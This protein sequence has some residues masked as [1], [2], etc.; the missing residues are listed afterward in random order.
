MAGFKTKLNKNN[1][2]KQDL[3][4]CCLKETHFRPRDT[5]RLKVRGWKNI[6]HA[7]GHQKKA[8]VA[9]LISDKIDFKIKTITRDKEGHYIMIKGSIQE[10]Y[11][12]IVNIYSPNVAAPQYIR[13]MLTAIKWEI[14]GNT[15]IVGDFITPLSPMDRS[16]K[17]K[18]NKETQ[19]LNTLNKMNF[20]DIYRTFNPKT[21]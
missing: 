16:S 17:V 14:D 10:E 21:T 12:T 15:I 20:I 19:A 7:N 2:N 6:F 1:N 3:Y 18:I 11:I 5:Y 13:Q 8:G 4:I 9:I